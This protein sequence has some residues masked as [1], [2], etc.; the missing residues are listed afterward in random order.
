MDAIGILEEAI[1]KAI[2]GN[3]VYDS[4]QAQWRYLLESYM[5]G[6]EYKNARHL[7]RYQLETDGE[8]QSRLNTTPLDNHCASV[9]S[10]YNSF[11]FRK[12]PDRDLATLDGMPEVTDFLKDAD[13]AGR[14]LDAFMKEV[15]TWS[16][17][18]GNCWVMVTKPDIGATNR[19]QEQQAGVRP[20]VSLLTPL[21]VLDWSWVRLPSGRYELDRFRYIEDINNEIQ[22]IKVWTK[23][24]IQT[25]VIDEENSYC[26]IQQEKCSAWYWCFGHC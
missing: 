6:L 23:E 2:A 26:S 3:D 10:V 4:Y 25:L 16:S 8:Y 14:S 9:I 13:F 20:Y 15:S 18:F 22:T 11:L 17:V 12:A 24:T 1:A 21:A 5:G 19:A 7:V